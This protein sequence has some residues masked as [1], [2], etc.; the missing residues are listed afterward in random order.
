MHHAH[1]KRKELPMKAFTVHDFHTNPGLRRRLFAEARR[2]RTRAL[3]AGLAWLRQR[4][5]AAIGPSLV[6]RRLARLG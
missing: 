2:E 3:L 5:P 4:L 1:V 6:G